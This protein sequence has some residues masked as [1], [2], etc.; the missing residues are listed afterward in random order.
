MMNNKAVTI[1]HDSRKRDPWLVRW[2][3]EYDPVAG[4]QRR[5]SKAFKRKA[6]AE[7]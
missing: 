4:K 2:Y 7:K 1:Q 3:G 5:Y 6:D